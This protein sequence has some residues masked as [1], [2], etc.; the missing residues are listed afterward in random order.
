MERYNHKW[1]EIF[2]AFERMFP[3][4][5]RKAT[6]WWPSGRDEITVKFRDRTRMIFDGLSNTGRYINRERIDA[7]N[8]DEEQWLKHFAYKLSRKVA[9]SGM[10]QRAI[11]EQVGITPAMLSRYCKG[12]SVPSFIKIK[13][14]SIVLQ[15]SVT[16][17]T[18]FAD[19]E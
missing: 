3:A 9:E 4:M 10:S 6:D 5:A 7:N 12:T 18:E 13:K 11:A 17:L 15:C 1:S 8:G 19:V 16:E 14:L 2:E